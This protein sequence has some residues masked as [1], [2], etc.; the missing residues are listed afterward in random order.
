MISLVLVAQLR[1]FNLILFAVQPL[2]S[3]SLELARHWSATGK[4][5]CLLRSALESVQ[6]ISLPN[7]IVAQLQT[8]VVAMAR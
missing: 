1:L 5:K 4:R 6:K 2:P 7:L 8:N 3:H